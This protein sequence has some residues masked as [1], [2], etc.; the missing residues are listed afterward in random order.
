[1]SCS[2]MKLKL[3]C[4]ATMTVVTLMKNG[5]NLQAWE[6]HTNCKVWGCFA[7]GGTGDLHKTD[8]IVGKEHCTTCTNIEATSQ[9]VSQE[10]KAWV[11][12]G[13]P[14]EQWPWAY[15]Q[16]SYKVAL[17]TTR[18]MFRSGLNC[19][20]K[21]VEGYPKLLSQVIQF[22]GNATKYKIL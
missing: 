13:L 1:M 15:C 18:L 16:M 5:G 10:V 22:K 14:N 6:P 7:A 21:L 20:E 17:S 9:D 3:N 11:Q 19:C 12:M 2:L 4:L 8:C